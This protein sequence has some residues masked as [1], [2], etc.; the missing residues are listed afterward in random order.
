MILKVLEIKKKEQ[1]KKKDTGYETVSKKG[2]SPSLQKLNWGFNWNCVLWSD[3]A[4]IVFAI[5][6]D[7]RWLWS[8]NDWFVEKHLMPTV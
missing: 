4:E 3:E 6:K 8:K 2:A 5:N 1:K 7:S